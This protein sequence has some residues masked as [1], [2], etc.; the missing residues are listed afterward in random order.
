M[1]KRIIIN[2]RFLTQRTTGVQRYQYEMLLG[3]DYN[4]NN[5]ISQYSFELVCPK[6]KLI[7]I[8]KLKNIQIVQFG[9]L[10]GHL[11]EQM[12]LRRYKDDNNSILISL[13]ASGPIYSTDLIVIHDVGFLYR[14]YYNTGYRIWYKGSLPKSV[15]SKN[16]T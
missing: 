2:G 13:T 7:N 10:S 15:G 1:R 9:N 4:L 6:G 5:H 12:D 16:E 3:I 8:P 14:S 11:W